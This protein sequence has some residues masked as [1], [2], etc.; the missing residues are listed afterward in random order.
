[1]REEGMLAKIEDFLEGFNQPTFRGMR[2]IGQ[3]A[4]TWSSQHGW[5]GVGT[6]G[7]MRNGSNKRVRVGTTAAL[8]GITAILA[9]IEQPSCW[10]SLRYWF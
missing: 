7:P 4:A 10:R 1:M 3:R 8:V 6:G 9:V 2:I 5:S